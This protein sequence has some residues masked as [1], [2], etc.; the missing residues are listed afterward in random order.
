MKYQI[1]I[2][3]K[4]ISSFVIEAESEEEASI[5]SEDIDDEGDLVDSYVE[6]ITTIEC[7]GNEKAKYTIHKRQNSKYIVNNETKEII[8]DDL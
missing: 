4:I 6:C 8:Y 1:T 2:E 7:D 3:S 5:Y